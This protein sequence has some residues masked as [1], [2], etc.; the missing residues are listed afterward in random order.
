ML[1]RHIIHCVQGQLRDKF[2]D[3]VWGI[4]NARVQKVHLETVSCS[5]KKKCNSCVLV[6]G[7]DVQTA[8]TVTQ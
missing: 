7:T 6:Q 4:E 8:G 3:A 1:Q 5:T 2:L